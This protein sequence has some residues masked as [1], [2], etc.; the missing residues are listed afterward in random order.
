[1]N[2]LIRSSVIFLIFVSLTACGGGGGGT[3]ASTDTPTDTSLVF[4]A[5]PPGYFGGSYS[6]S[7]SLT[8][9]ATNATSY[10]ATWNIQSAADTTF[11]SKSVKAIQQLLSIT[12]TTTNAVAGATAFTYFTT[13]L[14]NLTVEG[15]YTPTDGVSSFATS[16]TVIPLTATIGNFGSIGNYTNSDGTS[17]STTWALADGF[18][19]NAKLIIT[20]VDKDSSNVLDS[21]EIQKWLIS[22]DGTRLSV[23]VIITFHQDNNLTVTLAGS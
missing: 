14:N 12:N 1:M 8:G 23:E 19:G 15:S 11:N 6:D 13:D 17:S 21:T 7:I 9:T 3:T 20:F 4:S 5:F 2:T 16:T 22:Q 10:T 18:N